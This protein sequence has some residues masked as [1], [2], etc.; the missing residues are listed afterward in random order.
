MTITPLFVYTE[1]SVRSI[2]DDPQEEWAIGKDFS[3]DDE[4]EDIA[5]DNLVRLITDC[6]AFKRELFKGGLTAADI[7]RLRADKQKEKEAKENQEKEKQDRDSSEGND[8]ESLARVSTIA[9]RVAQKVAKELSEAEKRLLASMEGQVETVLRRIGVE[10]KITALNEAVMTLKGMEERVKNN[11][12]EAM[13][14]LEGNVIQSILDFLRNPISSTP[15]QMSDTPTGSES[16]E[17]TREASQVPPPKDRKGSSSAACADN[18]ASTEDPQEAFV[19]TPTVVGIPPAQQA[20]KAPEPEVRIREV[21]PGVTDGQ[22]QPS[23]TITEQIPEAEVNICDGSPSVPVGQT[24]TSDTLSEKVQYNASGS[25]HHPHA[26]DKCH[27]KESATAPCPNDAIKQVLAELHSVTDDQ[28]ESD[29]TAVAHETA[30]AQPEPDR[31]DMDIDQLPNQKSPSAGLDSSD[32]A[33]HPATA[34]FPAVEDPSFSLGVTQE[35]M[36]DRPVVACPIAIIPPSSSK[37][38]EGNNGRKS[39]RTRVA[40]AVLQDFQCDPKTTVPYKVSPDVC[41]AFDEIATLLNPIEFIILGDQFKISTW[42]FGNIAH[43]TTHMSPQVM[44]VIM[45]Y[46]GSIITGPVNNAAI[47]DSSLPG[48]LKGNYTR[49]VKTAV[50]DRHRVLSPT[51]SA[52]MTTLL[53]ETHATSGPDG[54]KG[55]TSRVLPDA[56]KQLVVSIYKSPFGGKHP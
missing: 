35:C 29:S 18:R 38:A 40:P 2:L 1:V 43:R 9:N 14:T 3:W 49:F 10:K 55:L 13:G 48:A 37:P 17:S 4:T 44:D 27:P 26:S 20:D 52:V 16:E 31:S 24:D 7:T 34:S 42:E 32:N 6:F 46:L 22:T 36:A 39:K 47:F 28:Q 5:V 23:E 33:E 56:A 12:A 41:L 15:A 11:V 21:S 51:D 30:A 54:C 45:A 53:I 50:K 25:A 19:S 8:G